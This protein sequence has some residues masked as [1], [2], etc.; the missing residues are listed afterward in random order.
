[1]AKN[2]RVVID[3]SGYKYGTLRIRGADGNIHHSSGNG[4]AVH[5]ATLLHFAKG[6]T[7]KQLV[8][9]NDLNVNLKSGNAGTQRMSAGVALRA[10]IKAGTAVKI[11]S[12]KVDRLNQKIDLPKVEDKVPAKPKAAKKAKAKAK[13]AAPRKRAPKPAA[14]TPQTETQ[15]AAV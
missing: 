15:Q 12:I 9:A 8:D 4:D 6:G 3:A 10:L 13:K 5:K 14:E 2:A 11:G 7:V 1:M